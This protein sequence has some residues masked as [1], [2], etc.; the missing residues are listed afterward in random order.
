MRIQQLVVA[1]GVLT[2]LA[3][4]DVAKTGAETPTSEKSQSPSSTDGTTGD[5]LSEKLPPRTRDLDLTGVD[6]CTD[7]L[8]DQQLRELAYDLGYNRPPLPEDSKVHDGPTCTYSST[9][10]SGNTNRDIVARIGVTT[11]QGAE[12]WLTDP[13]REASAELAEPATVEDFPALVMPHPDF[14]DSCMVIV[15]TA[16]GQYLSVAA[17]PASGE[18]TSPDPYCAEAERVAGMIIQTV[19]ASR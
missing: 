17:S 6:P 15:D 8:T 14:S 7:V 12:T 5:S 16:D 19:S 1:V 11:S 2:A 9:G 4:C 13:D 3:G 10:S 18:G